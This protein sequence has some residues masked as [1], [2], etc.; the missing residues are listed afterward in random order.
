MHAE[1]VREPDPELLERL[2]DRIERVLEEVRAAVEDWQAMR[3]KALELARE[4]EHDPRGVDATESREVRAFLEW[5]ADDHFTFLGYREYDLV[6]DGEQ[7]SLKA[8]PETGLGHPP[9]SALRGAA[10]QLSPKGGALARAPHLLVLTKANSRSTVHRPSYLDYIGVKRFDAAGN[11]TGERRFL[12]LYTSTAYRASPRD[13]PLLRGK[14]S[15]VLERAGF[16]PTSHDAKALLEILESYPRDALFQIET[17]DLFAVAMGLLGLGERQRVRLFT[18]E[19][20]LDRFVSC[21]VTIPRD[22]F[23][24]ENRERIGRILLEAF[25]GSQL[26]WSLQLSES[27]LVRVHYIIHCAGGVPAGYD[28]AEIERRLAQATRA[29]SDELRQALISV[30][31]EGQG[32]KLFRRYLAAFSTAYRSDWSVADA[33]GDIDRIEQLKERGGASIDLYRRA[34]DRGGLIRCKLYTSAG[35]SLSEVVPTFEHMGTRVVDERPYEVNPQGGPSAWIYDF[36]LQCSAEDVERVRDLFEDVFL[37]ARRGAARGRPAQR[38]R[39]GGGAD[40]IG[41]RRAARDRA[42]P[43]AGGDRVLGRV[44]AAHVAG[45]SGRHPPD[46]ASVHRAVRSDSRPTRSASGSSAERWSWRS[47]ESRVSTRT[48]SSAASCRSSGRCCGPT[49]SAAM[50]PGRGGHSCRSRSSRGRSRCCRD[51][52]PSSRC[53]S[54]RRAS[55]RSICAA[56]RSRGAG[57]AGRT[58]PRTSAPRSWG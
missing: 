31:G 29:W 36:G 24:T 11:V 42:V 57:S 54:T 46:P 52:G 40:R 7:T 19:D 38:T 9:P 30:H 8:L 55:K 10:S 13:I 3:G 14:V 16:L 23:N 17:E 48:G 45:T 22:R 5:V 47:T 43:E 1:V 32:V 49:T 58:G 21:L 18:W 56:A 28:V 12:G 53:S 26:D 25:G 6:A 33:V 39:P 51:R 2:H 34:G 15:T 41:N 4:L 27:L 37:A 44:H 20:P 50:S 35:V